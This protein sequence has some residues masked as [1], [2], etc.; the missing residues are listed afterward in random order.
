MTSKHA[1]ASNGQ[2]EAEKVVDHAQTTIKEMEEDI[3]SSV[4]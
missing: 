4:N 2:V 1:R 3:A